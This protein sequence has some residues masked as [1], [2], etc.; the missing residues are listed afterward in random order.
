MPAEI[1]LIGGASVVIKYGFREMPYDMASILNVAS[2]MKD[3]MNT[4]LDTTGWVN[5]DFLRTEAYTP[6]IVPFTRYYKTNYNVVTFRT[7][8]GEYLIALKLRSRRE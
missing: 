1:I 6:R 7:A 4:A 5:D 3:A 8:T 2:L